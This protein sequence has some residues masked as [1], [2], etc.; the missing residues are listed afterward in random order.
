YAINKLFVL[1]ETEIYEFSENKLKSV[2]NSDSILSSAS[3]S[4]FS[5]DNLLVGSYNSVID[6]NLSTR[7]V[8]Q[9]AY[10]KK[11][12][13]LVFAISSSNG[14]NVWVASE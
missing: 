8:E 12:Y 9:R 10:S 7:K 4:P 13:G 5:A 2:Y 11:C 3:A 6:L 14:Q 1:S